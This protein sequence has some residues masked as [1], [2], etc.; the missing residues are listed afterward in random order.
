MI[1]PAP[2]SSRLSASSVRRSAHGAGAER[3]ADRQLPFAPDRPRENQVGDVRAGD[4]E[5]QR[6]RRQQHEQDRPRRRGDLVAQAD[7]FDPEVAR[8]VGYDSGCAL[9]IARVHGAQ[10]GARR[11]ERRAG[12]EAR[13]ELRH[14]VHAAVL[15]SSPTDDAGWSRCWR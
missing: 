13:E 11:L 4:D 6:R 10:L 12:R 8:S 1:A 7:G 14:P 9:T 15:P 5:H 3:R 2:Q